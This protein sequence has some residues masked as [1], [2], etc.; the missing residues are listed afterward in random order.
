MARGDEP[1]FTM[2]RVPYL[3]ERHC[4]SDMKIARL[5]CLALAEVALL[6]GSDNWKYFM[7]FFIRRRTEYMS[8]IHVYIHTE[9]YLVFDFA[10]V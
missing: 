7:A 1:S 9:Y 4:A 2:Y 8:L 10:F 6:R 3:P 5:P